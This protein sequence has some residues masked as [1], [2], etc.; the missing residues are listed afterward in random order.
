M[1]GE[2]LSKFHEIKDHQESNRFVSSQTNLHKMNSEYLTPERT[3]PYQ[4][5]KI[6]SNDKFL[7]H[8]KPN[9][10]SMEKR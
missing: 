6:T 10:T 8:Q 5:I 4:N 1:Q 3:S 9:T 2:I 7:L